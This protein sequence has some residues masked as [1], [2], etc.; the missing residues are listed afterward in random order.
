MLEIKTPKVFIKKII[1]LN[2]IL[3]L[4]LTALG[5][6]IMF[7][8]YTIISRRGIYRYAFIDS[9]I[10]IIFTISGVIEILSCIFLK[11]ANYLGIKLN[12]LS[13]LILKGNII[14]CI[15]FYSGTYLIGTIIYK[16]GASS[17]MFI[18]SLFIFSSLLF[19]T[20]F[21]FLNIYKNRKELKTYLEITR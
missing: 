8:I 14:L 4:F 20:S 15:I 1:I 19:L 5:M 9:V 18:F 12:L 21:L 11:K 7:Y 17:L 6:S 2:L 16:S 13:L 3:G 10:F